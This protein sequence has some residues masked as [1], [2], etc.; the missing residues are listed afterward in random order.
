LRHR[1]CQADGVI[2]LSD[3][4]VPASCFWTLRW[5]AISTSTMNYG[6]GTVAHITVSQ[7]R[8]PRALLSEVAGSRRMLLHM[9]RTAGGRHAYTHLVFLVLDVWGD[10]LKAWGSVVSNRIGIK[11]GNTNLP[12]FYPNPIWNHGA[13]GCF[14]MAPRQQE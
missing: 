12:N 13:S 11:F 3:I 5:S 7:W 2:G 6:S 4:I 14:K 8:R 9:Q 10:L 1:Q